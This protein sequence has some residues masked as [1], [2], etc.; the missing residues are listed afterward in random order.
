MPGMYEFNMLHH[1]NVR[2]IDKCWRFFTSVSQG[3][4]FAF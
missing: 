4:H 1:T 3:M 2:S